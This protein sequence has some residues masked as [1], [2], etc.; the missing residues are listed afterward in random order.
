MGKYNTKP[1]SSTITR[2]IEI[3]NIT[4]AITYILAFEVWAANYLS[5]TDI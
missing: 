4:S 3:N 5:D 1:L 2:M